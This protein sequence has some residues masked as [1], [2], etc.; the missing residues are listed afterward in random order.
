LWEEVYDWATDS[1]RG[2]NIYTFANPGV[3]GH[4]GST[5]TSGSS[6]TAAE[7]ATRPVTT[8]S[9]RD[10]IVW[11]NAYSELSGKEPVYY[12]A[13]GITILR[14]STNTAGVGTDADLAVMDSTKNGYRLPTEAKWEYAAR[15]GNQSNT[16]NWDYT[17]AGTSTAGTGSGELG[18]YA[19][20]DSNSS[21]LGV[22]NPA[23]GPHPVGTKMANAKDLYDMSGNVWEW[24]W[25]WYDATITGTTPIDGPA[26]GT[27]RV[28]R[29]GSYE[30]AAFECAVTYRA[31][32]TPIY[33]S[34]NVGFRVACGD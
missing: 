4:G 3:E 18:D 9:W 5:G 6:W 31:S 34:S 29:S 27:V 7:K 23:F 26:S 13:D 12:K 17:Y 25:D 33:T 32:N 16:T 22:T 24:C 20:Y 1:A 21:S 19:W 8:I 15:G 14:V 28:A 2:A 10:A 30:H 11:C